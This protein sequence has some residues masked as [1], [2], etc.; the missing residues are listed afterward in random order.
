MAD[1]AAEVKTFTLK[2]TGVLTKKCT[3][4]ERISSTNKYY[5]S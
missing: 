2:K 4:D 3:V 1:G 5:V